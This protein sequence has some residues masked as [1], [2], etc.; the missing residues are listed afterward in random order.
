M[1]SILIVNEISAERE[2][3]V[4]ALEAEGFVVVQAGSPADAVREIWAGTFIVAIVSSL[5]TGTTAQQLAEQIQQMAPEIETLIQ[6]KN[7]DLGRL[8]RKVSDIRDGVAAA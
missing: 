6:N 4:R 5:L 3:L 7:D 8:V 2:E 1:S